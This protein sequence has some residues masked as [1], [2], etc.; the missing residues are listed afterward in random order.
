MNLLARLLLEMRIEFCF[1]FSLDAESRSVLLKQS[2]IVASIEGVTLGSN[3]LGEVL[4]K[5]CKIN[6]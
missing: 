3:S 4:F 2:G 1:F 6:H 5:V